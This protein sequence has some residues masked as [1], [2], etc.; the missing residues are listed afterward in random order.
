MKLLTTGQFAKLC[1]TH[2]GTLFFYDSEGLLKPKYVSGNGYRRYGAEQY[3][4]FDLI[5]MLKEAGSS[6]KEIKL[7]LYSP[8][9]REILDFLEE[10]KRH[11]REEKIKLA[12]RYSMLE[13][14][15]THVRT[16]HETKYDV[17]EFVE[18]KEERLESVKVTPKSQITATD[19]VNLLLEHMAYLKLHGDMPY[20]S[21]GVCF[22]IKEIVLGQFVPSFVF[23][24]ATRKTNKENLHIK[25]QGNYAVAVHRGTI[26]SH[27]DA[28]KFFIN[29]IKELEFNISENVYVYDMASY[30]NGDIHI[31]EYLREYHFQII[32][33]QVDLK[34]E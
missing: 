29:K 18:M 24:V 11:L 10:K 33:K 13:E 32:P 12:R 25:P 8:E 19:H 23:H 9:S 17:L 2:K 15:I 7:Y 6:L 1:G 28:F 3:F 4:I 14:L 26:L 31:E 5:T 34:T 20:Q 21:M 27:C 16:A 22:N 30:I